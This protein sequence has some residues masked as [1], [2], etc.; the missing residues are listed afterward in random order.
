[1]L[2]CKRQSYVES[3]QYI[4][5]K[6]QFMSFSTIDYALMGEALKLAEKG[7][8]S[9]HPNPQVGCVI[10]HDG[11]VVGRG[12]HRRAGEPHAEIHALQQAGEKARG[13]S[14]YVT[15][16][17]CCHHGRT[18]PCSQALIQA[19]V[20]RVVVAMEDPNPQVAGQGLA[21]LRAAGITVESGLCQ[22]QAEELNR[23]FLHR[24]KTGRPW[25]RCKLAMTL[26]G[27]TALP[28]GE[29]QWITSPDSRKLVHKIRAQSAVLLT[30]MGTVLADNPTLNVRL[31]SADCMAYG[32]DETIFQQPMRCV[33][34]PQLSFDLTAKMRQHQ[35]FGSAGTIYVLTTPQSIEKHADKVQ[36]LEAEG[37][38]VQAVSGD[39]N[40]LQLG[41]VMQYLGVLQVNS[42][43]VE[44]GATLCGAL[45]Q[46]GLVDELVIFMAPSL[47][48]D[49]G[50]G[51]FRLTGIEQMADKITLD[52]QDI[53]AVGSDWCILAKPQV[54][55]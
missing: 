32:L 18:P 40:A 34:D 41:E 16:E 14:V 55:H 2:S 24:I 38:V 3:I 19:G 33:L 25:V 15:L 47:L 26:D 35:S 27:R 30:G 39:Q 20:S 29:S 1:M 6:L 22:A 13:S 5:G 9:A 31:E 53:R 21:E 42:V 11:K 50:R 7:Q 36:R 48:G 52:I 43:M 12:W 4:D 49:Q 23:G 46:A 17:P 54:A 10:T 44:A 45:L 37:I 51:L 28:S 8:F